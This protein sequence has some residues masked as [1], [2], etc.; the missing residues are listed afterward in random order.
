MTKFVFKLPDLGEGVVE[1]EIVEW[2]VKAGDVVKEDDNLCDVMTDKATVEIPAPKDGTVLAISG[3]P[4]DIISVGSE[5][6]ALEVVGAA[7]DSD[8]AQKEETKVEA[9]A[10]E[11]GSATPAAAPPAKAAPI[12]ERHPAPEPKRE[13]VVAP[14]RALA[15]PAVRR[16]AAEAG[17]DL[18]QVPGSGP[19]GRVTRD[20]FEGFLAGG[21][22]VS[23]GRSSAKLTGTNEIKVIGLRRK[24]AEK[25]QTAKRHIPHFTYVEEMDV[26]ELEALRKHLNDHRM[27][28]QPKLTVLPFLMQA[29]VKVLRDFP[30]VNATFDDEAGVITRYEGAHIGI[31]T[32]TDNGLM[33]PV[34]RHAESLDI[35]ESASEVVR[36]SQA[37]RGNS[38]KMD[39]LTGSS[40]TITSLGALGGVVSTPVIN[41]PEVAIIGI[42]KMMEK[43]VME[44]GNV[45]QRLVMNISTSC[46]HRVVDGFVAAQAMQ[47]YKAL[48]EHP[49]TI[50]M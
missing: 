46:D 42:N 7:G 22:R 39:E 2:H 36:L 33:V 37:T 47:S 6:V 8:E 41:H 24:I 17:V 23:A 4:G 31:A 40:I 18:I 15:S 32:Q 27:P 45:T 5:L 38:A 10:P 25:M 29:L 13:G 44:N 16:R 1:A 34:V 43:L 11:P 50:F 19:R 14:V 21:G 48:L 26:T 35:W 49:A 20:D 3:E 12:Q 30:E 28:N 9:K